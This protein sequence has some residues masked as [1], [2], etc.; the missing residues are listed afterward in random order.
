MKAGRPNEYHFRKP[1]RSESTWK[2]LEG[3]FHSH[4][5]A[6]VSCYPT[7][8]L[9]CPMCKQK[10]CLSLIYAPDDCYRSHL[11][12][13]SPLHTTCVGQYDVGFVCVAGKYHKQHIFTRPVFL[14]ISFVLVW[15]W[16]WSG[17]QWDLSGHLLNNVIRMVISQT[18]Q[19]F[20]EKTR[21]H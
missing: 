2:L 21:N 16:F 15:G 7:F 20:K 8:L 4:G 10:L 19:K 5:L 18:F 13:S 11:G 3:V 6:L 14:S 12:R 9:L 1:S 17:F